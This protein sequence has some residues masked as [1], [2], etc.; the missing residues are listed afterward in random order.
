[1]A[2]LLALALVVA[3]ESARAATLED[4]EVDASEELLS[5]PEL[6]DSEEEVEEEVEFFPAL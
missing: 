3:V 6:V 2:E 1:M 5:F 4:V